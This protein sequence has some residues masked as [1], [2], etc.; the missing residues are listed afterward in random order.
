MEHRKIADRD[1][2]A[3]GLGAMPMSVAGRGDHAQSIRTIHASLTA[4][5][6]LIDTADAYCMDSSEFGHNETLI[7]EALR[8]WGGDS[9]D[10]LVATK[11]GHTRGSDGSWGVNGRPEY[12]HEACEASLRRLG[13]ESIG[14]YQFHRPD[15]EVPIEESVGALGQLLDAGKIRMAGVSNVNSEQIRIARE[16]LGGRLASVQNQYSP[17]FRSSRIELDLCAEL[18]IA[19]LPWSPL[20]GISRAGELGATHSVFAEVAKEHGVTPQQVALAWMLAASDVVVP[21]PGASRPKSAVASAAASELLLSPE[22]L[23]R[24]NAS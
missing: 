24:L 2:S 1:V 17:S 11:G 15:P 8:H 18:G 20:G 10:V 3:I 22:Q 16:V 19:F 23:A 7:A 6:T 5:V 21:I 9:D 13:V 12:L 14:L 4:G